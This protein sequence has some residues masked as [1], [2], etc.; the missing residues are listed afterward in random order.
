M[1]IFRISNIINAMDR[2]R[3]I[4]TS[5]EKKIA[6]SPRGIFELAFVKDKKPLKNYEYNFFK[7]NPSEKELVYLIRYVDEIYDGDWPEAEEYVIN[8][9]KT[10][11]SILEYAYNCININPN[12][13][14]ISWDAGEKALL[15]IGN[16]STIYSYIKEINSNWDE[17]VIYILDNCRDPYYLYKLA[18]SIIGDR[19]DYKQ[20]DII[21]EDP[22][23][24]YKYSSFFELED[25]E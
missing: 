18:T 12:R 14:I 15:K 16:I 19:L 10:G 1:S 23:I 25:T 8:N 2:C 7:K 22:E 3:F 21:S 13:S 9:D 6:S 20:E 4:N 24:W 5:L 11:R 17:G